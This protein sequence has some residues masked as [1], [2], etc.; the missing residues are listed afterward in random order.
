MPQETGQINYC[1]Q[2]VVCMNEQKNKEDWKWRIFIQPKNLCL[3]CLDKES[4]L[5]FSSR[6]KIIVS[7]FQSIF[8]HLLITLFTQ[9]MLWHVIQTLILTPLLA[10]LTHCAI[11]EYFCSLSPEDQ[12]SHCIL[13]YW[14]FWISPPNWG[15][16]VM[17]GWGINNEQ[18]GS[19][20]VSM[21]KS[22]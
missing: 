18:G 9:W 20:R 16:E 11:S 15:E 17:G 5:F 1:L 2:I 7:F 4:L 3:F 13:L 19:W 12:L 6:Q 8:L 14:T 22:M 21:G 10:I